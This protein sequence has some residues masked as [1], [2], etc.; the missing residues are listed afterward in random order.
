M[1]FVI[2][3]LLAILL[4][5]P[6][7]VLAATDYLEDISVSRYW[8]DPQ[9][10]TVWVQPCKYSKIAYDA[11]RKWM[12]AANGCIRFVDAES[13]QSANIKV[14]FSNFAQIDESGNRVRH[15][16]H[17]GK[18][19]RA[20]IIVIYTKQ[21]KRIQIESVLLYEIGRALGMHGYTQETMSIITPNAVRAVRR[22]L[23]NKDAATIQKMYCGR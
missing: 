20:H 6:I 16:E 9:N 2:R 22:K 8:D 7:Q 3:F 11:F 10:I 12:K 5:T 23:T 21:K 1:K 18:N 14:Y 13:E 15:F 17:Y 4:I 19:I